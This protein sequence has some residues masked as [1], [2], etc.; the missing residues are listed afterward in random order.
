MK[1][2]FLIFFSGR[3]FALAFVLAASFLAFYSPALRA[4]ERDV[5]VV[6]ERQAL[7]KDIQSTIGSL[8]AMVRGKREYNVDSLQQLASE[9][10]ADLHQLS[11]LFDEPSTSENSYANRNIWENKAA[12]DELFQKASEAIQQLYVVKNEADLRSSLVVLGNSCTACHRQF[13]LQK[14]K[15]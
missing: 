14:P 12:F 9:I 3:V 13:R 4:A 6:K 8:S 2:E 10:K 11:S 15:S 7:M 5:D 1:D